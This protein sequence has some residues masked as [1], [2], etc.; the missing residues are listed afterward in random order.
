ML[1]SLQS[2]IKLATTHPLTKDSPI[3]ALARI[4]SW[5]VR[6]RMKDEV[7]T[8]W[9]SGQKLVCSRGM[10]GGTGNIYVGLQEFYDMGFVL[11]FLKSNDLFLDVGAN[12]GSYTVLAAGVCHSKV[13]AFEPALSALKVLKRNI[14]QNDLSGLV[15]IYECALGDSDTDLKFTVGLDVTNHVSQSDSDQVISVRQR[16]LDDVVGNEQPIMAKIDVEGYE[17][18]VLKGAQKLLNNPSM[19]ALQVET[20]TQGLTDCLAG[21]GFT[22]TFY[23][24]TDRTF[25]NTQFGLGPSNTLFIR[26]RELVQ[27]RVLAAP[28]VQILS[29]S[30]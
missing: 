1:A 12:I 29:T 19:Q 22:A 17:E 18:T 16:R 4:A 27:N 15:T 11:H 6:S 8:N 13:F 2:Y 14:E 5:Q 20:L 24:P 7:T 28:R 10:H 30:I 3:S 23:N 9:I 21:H 26:S 25:S